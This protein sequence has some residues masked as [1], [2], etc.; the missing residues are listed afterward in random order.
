MAY[1]MKSAVEKIL[2]AHG[3]LEA[4]N[5]AEHYA[6][7][8]ASGGYMPLSIEKHGKLITVT[9]Y[10]EQNGDLVP[11]PDMEFVDLGGEEWLPVA[12]QH[13]TGLYY[14]KAAEQAASGNWLISK[15]AMRD[16]KSF[17]RMG[18]AISLFKGSQLANSSATRPTNGLTLSA[19][20]WA[21]R[22]EPVLGG[23]PAGRRV[24]FTLLKLEESLEWDTYDFRN[25]I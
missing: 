17:A 13:S 2:K 5:S 22:I 15:H 16:L 20:P 6:A 25:A 18:R 7:K 12:I 21:D 14:C 4:F 24:F 9:H 3:V 1:T 8:I 10:F 11:D 23:A 19:L